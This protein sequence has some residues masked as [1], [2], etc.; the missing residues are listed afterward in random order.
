MLQTYKAND[1]PFL[2]KTVSR[3]LYECEN[4]NC[5]EDLVKIMQ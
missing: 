4:Y 1:L 3:L 2:L 5:S